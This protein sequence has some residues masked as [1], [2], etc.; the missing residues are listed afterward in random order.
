MTIFFQFSGRQKRRL[1]RLVLLEGQLIVMKEYE[2]M[3]CANTII[4]VFGTLICYGIWIFTF[5][6]GFAFY[7]VW[8]VQ[9]SAW[10]ITFIS[11]EIID[12]IFFEFGIEIFIGIL[13]HFRTKNNSIRNFGE[14]LNR[15]RCY[16]TLY[17]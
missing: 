5:Y 15:L 8:K 2:D 14:W 10:I 16:R 11:S 6:M 13:Y 7:A 12:L 9:K 3:Q 17:P 1:L 4:T